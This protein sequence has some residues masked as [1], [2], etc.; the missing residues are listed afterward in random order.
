MYLLIVKASV[1]DGWNV[2]LIQ[3]GYA[4]SYFGMAPVF[5]VVL[6]GLNLGTSQIGAYQPRTG[7]HSVTRFGYQT[8]GNVA[9]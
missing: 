8:L 1:D 4:P 7:Y 5:T 3:C 6:T 9:C 2:E